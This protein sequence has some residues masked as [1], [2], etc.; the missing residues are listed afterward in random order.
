VKLTRAVLL[1]S[2]AAVLAMRLPG[3]L[4]TRAGPPPWY[5]EFRGLTIGEEAAWALAAIT[6]GALLFGKK[7][8]RPWCWWT[9]AAVTLLRW[10]IVAGVGLYAS[11]QPIPGSSS[12]RPPLF[13][14]VALGALGPVLLAASLTW[15][16]WA[17]LV[18]G[19]DLAGLAWPRCESCGYNLTG[20]TSGR[21]PECGTAIGRAET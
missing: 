14:S 6:C 3:W 15:Y 10:S 20:N 4:Q 9:F 13:A 16:W 18:A 8:L 19:G 1:A 2:G 17:V 21:C 5:P 11:L 12:Y 7:R